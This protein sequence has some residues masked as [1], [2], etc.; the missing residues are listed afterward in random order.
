MHT[1]R[2]R[3]PIE[4]AIREA[5]PGATDAEVARVEELLDELAVILLR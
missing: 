5:V 3:G 2:R 4:S 1:R